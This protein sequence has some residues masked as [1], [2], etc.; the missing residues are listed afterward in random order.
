M[1]IQ[2]LINGLTLGSVYALIALVSLWFGLL[3]LPLMTDLQAPHFGLERPLMVSAI[4]AVVGF[5]KLVASRWR[6]LPGHR[7]DLPDVYESHRV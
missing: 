5:L 6:G 4:V 3:S 1:L 2:Q 7:A